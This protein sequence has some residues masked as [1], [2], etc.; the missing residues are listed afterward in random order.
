MK[1]PY[2]T[3]DFHA[4]RDEGYYYADRT[5]RIRAQEETGKQLLFLRPRRSRGDLA[6]L[7]WRANR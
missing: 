7:S 6:P 5:D 2:G 3:A 1:F 4:I